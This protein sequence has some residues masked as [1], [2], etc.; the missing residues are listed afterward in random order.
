M[1]VIQVVGKR[2]RPVPILLNADMLESMKVLTKTRE[3]CNVDS[4]FFFA[5]PGQRNS[6]LHYYHT[7]QKVARA[8]GM[9]RPSLLTTTR[10]RKHHATMAQVRAVVFHKYCCYY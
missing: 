3:V 5:I 2:Q 6:R 1:K 4:E 8:A 7:L 9:N 10:M